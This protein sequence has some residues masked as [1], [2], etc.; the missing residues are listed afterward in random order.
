[1]ANNKITKNLEWKALKENYK[2]GQVRV[3]KKFVSVNEL[4]DAI[5]DG[6]IHALL[7]QCADEL[8]DGDFSSAIRTFR[9]N[10]SSQLCN[11]KKSNTTPPVDFQ[12]YELLD[13]YTEQFVVKT[14]SAV[15][16]GKA[17]VNYNHDDIMTLKGN[18]EELRKLY[19]VFADRKSKRPESLDDEFYANFELIKQ[20]KTEAKAAEDKVTVSTDILAK[21]KAGVT[22]TAEESAELVKLLTK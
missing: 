1:M 22:L 18:H 13:K 16:A 21:L 17:K 10:L 5:A 7:Q 20:L 4:A 14:T 15:V 2:I 19:N 12:R 6:E 11:M 3:G 9:K 8:H